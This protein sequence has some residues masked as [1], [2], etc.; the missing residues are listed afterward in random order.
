MESKKR[1][2]D[3]LDAAKDDKRA[4][5]LIE[6][7]VSK[8]I[9]YV[10][11]VYDTE[12][13]RPINLIKLDPDHCREATERLHN[14]RSIMYNSLIDA[15]RVC[16]RYLF[17]TFGSDRIPEGGL[18]SEDPIHLTDDHY[19]YAVGSWAGDVFYA[20][21][22]DRKRDQDSIPLRSV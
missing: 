10:T 22:K 18:Y 17:S 13:L 8:V 9:G 4:V 15:I 11:A 20:F 12:T 5:D 1:I 3:I 19:R 21:F 7:V 6:V 2:L 14:H 16:N